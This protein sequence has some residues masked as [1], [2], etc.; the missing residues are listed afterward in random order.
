M[1]SAQHSEDIESAIVDVSEDESDATEFDSEDDL[2]DNF[3]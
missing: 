2:T 1:T 3:F